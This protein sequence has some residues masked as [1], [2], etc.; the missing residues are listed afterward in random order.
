MSVMRDELLKE[1]EAFIERTR[2]P[3][4]TF[5]RLALNDLGFV[6]RLRNG[7]DVNTATADK[8]REFMRTHKSDETRSCIVTDASEN[9]SSSP[10]AITKE[11]DRVQTFI[12]SKRL[13]KRQLA[14]RA[15][16]N[17]SILTG[18]ETERWAPQVSTLAA[19]SQAIDAIER[20]GLPTR[21]KR[22]GRDGGLG[23]RIRMARQSA[24]MTLAQIGE[25][26]NISKQAVG[27]WE[28]GMVSPP[29]GAIKVIASQTGASEV[30][31]HTGIGQQAQV[32][33]ENVSA[34]GWPKRV[35]DRIA[36]LTLTTTEASIG[37]GLE[38][39]F[40]DDLIQKRTAVSVDHFAKLAEFLG[41]SLDRLYYGRGEDL[42]LSARTAIERIGLDL[43]ETQERLVVLVAEVEI[44]RR[45]IFK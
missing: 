18:A 32:P 15:Q 22:T 23:G 28:N 39:T 43:R 16:L 44:L 41:L 42:S 35:L 8:L 30:W 38:P 10:D 37:A 11:R 29:E 4:T 5:G 21:H 20:E 45:A 19:L 36:S 6:R 17:P 26:F 13:S 31:L 12:R 9:R 25:L 1:I 40:L 27:H 7:A 2:M 24:H 33:G 14:L 3:Q 34:G